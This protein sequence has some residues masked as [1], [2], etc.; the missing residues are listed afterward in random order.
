MK[1]RGKGV[2]MQTPAHGR[3]WTDRTICELPIPESG[4]GVYGHLVRS[5]RKCHQSL[6]SLVWHAASDE[7]GDGEA[8]IC[9]VGQ[10]LIEERDN[11]I[12]FGGHKPG[13]FD[14]NNVP[15]TPPRFSFSDLVGY[16]PR[17]PRGVNGFVQMC[18]ARTYEDLKIAAA[19]LSVDEAMQFATTDLAYAF[20]LLEDARTLRDGVK[21]AWLRRD[22]SA[23]VSEETLEK[24]FTQIE[25]MRELQEK[26]D[27]IR[28]GARAGGQ[29]SA[30]TRQKEQRTPSREVLEREK[31]KLIESGEDQREVAAILAKRFNVAP[32]TI[33]ARLRRT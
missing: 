30:Q 2:L 6:L 17:P 19:L 22:L 5:L 18:H 24:A 27:R 25:A 21:L 23:E 7:A 28:K 29:K 3:L 20:H 12:H 16:G 9:R 13:W 15:I 32:G 31:K 26:Q 8:Y 33:R 10:R 1:D 11:P 14:V 4:E